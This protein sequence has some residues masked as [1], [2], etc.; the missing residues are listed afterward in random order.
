MCFGEEMA[1]CEV[2]L[3]KEEL[4]GISVKTDGIWT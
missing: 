3:S 4:E 2:G 1:D